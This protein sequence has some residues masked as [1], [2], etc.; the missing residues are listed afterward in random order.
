[1][2][3]GEQENTIRAEI[4][5][6]HSSEFYDHHAKR[7]DIQFYV[8]Y[9]VQS[10]GPVLELGCGTGRIVIPTAKDGIS[11][12]GLDNSDGMLKVCR[13]KLEDEAPEVRNRV[14]LVDAD[15]RGF[16]LG[17]EFA[18]ITV[19]FGP[20]NYLVSTDE[21]LSCLRCVEKHLSEGG[22]LI[23]D[24]WYPDLRELWKSEKGANIVYK[25]SPFITHD[26]RRVNWGIRNTAVDYGRQLI[27]EELYYDVTHPDGRKE[28]LVYPAP[29]RYFFCFEVEHLL[30]RAGFKVESVYADFDKRPFGSIYPSEMIFVACKA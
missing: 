4:Y 10:G 11:I 30:A 8:D 14:S 15:M 1:M 13:R 2:P 17:S 26:G 23:I 5:D 16:S 3:N 7:G 27:H 29:M 20:F 22:R 25:K 12:T 19:P 21:Q 28:R 18:L 6:N 24:F 9:A